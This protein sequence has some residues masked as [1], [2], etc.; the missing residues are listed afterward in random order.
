MNNYPPDI[1]V[2]DDC[3]PHQFADWLEN[4]VL[5]PDH[6]LKHVVEWSY[7]EN[8]A[9]PVVALDKPI[10][11][12]DASGFVYTAMNSVAPKGIRGSFNEPVVY[13]ITPL[14]YN[15]INKWNPDAHLAGIFR[16]RFILNIKNQSKG[17]TAPHRDLKCPHHTMIYYIN[18]SD[19]P[20]IVFGDNMDVIAEV[21]PRKGRVLIFGGHR[22]HCG[23][24]PEKSKHRMAININFELA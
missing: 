8:I 7:R 4:W 2:I 19:G 16:I 23:T 5:N 15:V 21:E 1:A 12:N 22:Y 11:E 10:P 17:R 6:S 13:L 18:D 3:I 14:V 24:M 9:I 20:T